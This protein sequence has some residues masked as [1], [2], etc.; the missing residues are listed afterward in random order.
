L[1]DKEIK[2][3]FEKFIKDAQKAQ[4]EDSTTFFEADFPPL[5]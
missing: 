4:I 2:D 5:S 3:A 1:E